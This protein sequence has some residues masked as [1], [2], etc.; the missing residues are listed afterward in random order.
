MVEQRTRNAQVVGPSPIFSSING[1]RIVNRFCLKIIMYTKVSKF[2]AKILRHQ[3]EI[4]GITL[5]ENGFAE[6]S[7][8]LKGIN[9]KGVYINFSMLE[10]IVNLDTKGRYAFNNDKTKIRARQGHSIKVELNLKKVTPPT[11]LYHG[12]VEKFLSGI[13]SEGL[14]KKSRNHV[15]LSKDVE[16]ATLVAS[17]RGTPIILEISA[18]EMANNGYE[19]Y[20]SEN[21]VFLTSEVPLKYIRLKN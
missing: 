19:F 17:R 5:D 4:I 6:V 15:H 14:I 12:T 20:I 16:T 10:E 21:G 9:E 11:F 13:L 18:L 8:V 7:E 3:P 1:W 2:L